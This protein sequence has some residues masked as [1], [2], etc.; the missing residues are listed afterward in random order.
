MFGTIIGS[1]LLHFQRTGEH[2]CSS[3][4]FIQYKENMKVR[5]RTQRN[6][7]SGVSANALLLSTEQ[8]PLYCWLSAAC[9]YISD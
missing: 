1:R 3:I 5:L 4:I 2:L 9:Y 8:S 7:T 6:E